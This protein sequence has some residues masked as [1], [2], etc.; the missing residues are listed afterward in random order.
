[1]NSG[2]GGAAVRETITRLSN[3]P[4]SPCAHLLLDLGISRMKAPV[5]SHPG[6][7]ASR[8]RSIPDTGRNSLIECQR[9]FTKEIPT[10][11]NRQF[12]DIAV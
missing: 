11:G 6:D 2:L 10:I 4:I 8:C 12:C 3:A 1:M 7:D 5:K 9:L